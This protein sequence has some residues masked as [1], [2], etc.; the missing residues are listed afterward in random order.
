M[1]AL[2]W[3]VY[4]TALE[5]SASFS[6]SSATEGRA[7]ILHSFF[8]ELWVYFERAR[9]YFVSK[10]AHSERL[11]TNSDSSRSQAQGSKH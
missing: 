6:K 10:S 4:F 3:P 1:I 2:K 9:L 11:S 7:L 8:P 5:I